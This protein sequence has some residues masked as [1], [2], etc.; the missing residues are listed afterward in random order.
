MSITKRLVDKMGG[1][2]GVES[3]QGVGTTYTI[4][5]PFAIDNTATEEPERQQTDLTV[6]RGR[7]PYFPHQ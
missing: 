2:I 7:P 1:T 4:T 3:K 6:L 5:L